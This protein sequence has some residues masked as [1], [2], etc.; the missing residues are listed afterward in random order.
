MR[1]SN[2]VPV[3]GGSEMGTRGQWAVDFL[4]A[5]GNTTPTVSTQNL[6]ASW[7]VG[8]GTAAKYNPL[9]TTLDYGTNTKFNNCC[10]GNGVKNYSSRSEGIQA[11][12]LTLRGKHPGYAK[13]LNGLRDN[14]PEDAMIGMMIAPWGTNFSHV[15]SVWRTRDVRGEALASE[16]SSVPTVVGATAPLP[17]R[18]G[19]LNS[20]Q[21]QAADVLRRTVGA[22]AGVGY[23]APN[24]TNN[25]SDVTAASVQKYVKVAF[26]IGIAAVSGIL[27]IIVLMKSDTVQSAVSIAKVA[28]I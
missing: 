26:G 5:I 20:A 18:S 3:L 15:Q 4:T 8:E 13:I 16:D 10:G 7:T 6:V 17:V 19:D 28:A 27:M 21:A 2:V 25:A 24:D 11:T 23:D 9:A 1:H 12:V 22:T 14:K